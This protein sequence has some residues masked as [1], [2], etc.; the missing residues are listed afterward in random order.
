MKKKKNALNIYSKTS[1][2]PAVASQSLNSGSGY[3]MGVWGLEPTEAKGPRGSCAPRLRETRSFC[4][5][6]HA[7]DGVDEEEHGDEEAHVWQSL[8][9]EE[10]GLE[11]STQCMRY[12]S[13]CVTLCV[14]L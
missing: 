11:V 9:T 5:D 14:C 1:F 4:T 7:D 13:S 12:C 10:G 8:Y 6:L 2:V 3:V